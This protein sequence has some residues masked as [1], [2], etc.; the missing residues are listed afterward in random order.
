VISFGIVSKPVLW[1]LSLWCGV[2]LV[3]AL[4]GR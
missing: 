3:V 4:F 1:S 2:F